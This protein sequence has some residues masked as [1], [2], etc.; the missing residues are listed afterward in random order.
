MCMRSP[1]CSPLNSR[2]TRSLIH[3][4][5]FLFL[6]PVALA[7]LTPL[8]PTS[9]GGYVTYYSGDDV[10]LSTGGSGVSLA[11]AL[12]CVIRGNLTEGF[13]TPPY[14]YAYLWADS[15]GW[16]SSGSC[17]VWPGFLWCGV[18]SD[19]YLQWHNWFH[20]TGG[21]IYDFRMWKDIAPVGSDFELYVP[22]TTAHPSGSGIAGSPDLHVYVNLYDA[23]DTQLFSVDTVY[24]YPVRGITAWFYGANTTAVLTHTSLDLKLWQNS[25]GAY[26]S[27][28]NGTSVMA[29]GKFYTAPARV[30]IR[31]YI[32]ECNKIQPYSDYEYW[33]NIDG[34]V[35]SPAT[36]ANAINFNGLAAGSW[37][38][39]GNDGK[40]IANNTLSGSGTLSYNQTSLND[41]FDDENTMG[42]AAINLA[43][44]SESGG[45]LSTYGK[46]NTWFSDA[47]AYCALPSAKL[48]DFWV[49]TSL[50]YTG[51]S[52]DLSVLYLTV[53]NPSGSTIAYAGVCDSWSAA[54]PQFAY[55]V[56]GG[57]SW[58]SGSNTMPASGTV[59]LRL[60][61]T[62]STWT[63][64]A[65]GAY[66][67]TW[68][69]SGSTDAIA[70]VFLTHNRYFSSPGKLAQWGYIRSNLPGYVSPVANG[71]LAGLC[72]YTHV[73]R[74][75]F[76]ANTT[77]TYHEDA[78]YFILVQ[79]PS[80]TTLTIQGVPA[81]DVVKVYQ[82][83]TLRKTVVSNGSSIV[84]TQAEI[85]QPF[86]GSVVVVSRPYLR[87]LAVYN[88]TL[89][90]NDQLAY[91]GGSLVKSGS[92]TSLVPSALGSECN[93]AA[94]WSLTYNLV[95][96]GTSPSLSASGGYVRVDEP[97]LHYSGNVMEA[98]YWL[99]YHINATGRNFTISLWSDAYFTFSSGG[100]IFEQYAEISSTTYLGGVQ[101]LLAT[102]SRSLTP[103]MNVTLTNV[104]P[105]SVITMDEII[106][107]A[108]AYAR[109]RR[110]YSLYSSNDWV[111]VDYLRVNYSSVPDGFAGIPVTGLQQG[112]RAA[113]GTDTYWANSSGALTIAVGAS[114]WP[115]N[116][117]VAVYPPSE[118]Y[119]ANF[120]LG[121]A[122]YPLTNKTYEP[123]TDT[124]YYVVSSEGY[125]YR[126][127]LRLLSATTVP[128][129]VGAT[130]VLNFTYL[131][132]EN[133]ALRE[134]GIPAIY[135]NGLRA[136]VTRLSDTYSTSFST[137]GNVQYVN[138]SS[139]DGTGIRLACRLKVTK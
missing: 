35:L 102:T 98:Y 59:T 105:S 89:D 58:G 17:P 114:T 5:L 123:A 77:I 52:G 136:A 92:N 23:T 62:G 26:F 44:L 117:V 134:R 80:Q 39:I 32:W 60:Q 126:V 79:I 104:S 19:G 87:P 88:G 34:V 45:Y 122:Y 25:S 43:T 20:S 96:G 82:G 83:E 36:A 111:R 29:T 76:H 108:H 81:N 75:T 100:D 120:T 47:G 9:S 40:V 112:W 63:I 139:V 121:M 6:L 2:R 14:T 116:Q 24:N 129:K 125:S 107:E 68:I 50:K 115:S 138:F 74:A 110:G 3:L 15:N 37:Y 4:S 128:G 70:G 86:H 97:Y 31:F 69:T 71:T 101:L 109:C 33:I 42:W 131:V 53:K 94:G 132:Y 18:T 56:T 57:S 55:G 64:T 13:S 84:V 106:V 113:F 72:N 91:S 1:S 41:E 67:G 124:I 38:L 48:G 127:E 93:D 137:P 118:S 133:G 51:Q 21:A 103:I 73:K 85:P 7:L 135:I 46:D 65:S 90:W 8:V 78:G 28:D 22:I 61:R 12:H 49:E 130:H 95:T 11:R 99:S 10:V 16:S 30:E 54:N 27:Y 119:K 66:S